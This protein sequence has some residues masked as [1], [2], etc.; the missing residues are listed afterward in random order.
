MEAMRP[1]RY[2]KNFYPWTSTSK[3]AELIDQCVDREK[4]IIK[5]CDACIDKNKDYGSERNTN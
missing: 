4:K 2:C 5:N 3:S 1:K